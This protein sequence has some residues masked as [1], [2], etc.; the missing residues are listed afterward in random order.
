MPAEGRFQGLGGERQG[1]MCRT[2]LRRVCSRPNARRSLLS[3]IWWPARFQRVQNSSHLCKPCMFSLIW[4][5]CKFW[6]LSGLGFTAAAAH[7]PLSWSL[8]PNVWQHKPLVGACQT[9]QEMSHHFAKVRKEITK[10]EPMAIYK[11]PVGP[12]AF[13]CSVLSNSSSG[14]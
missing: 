13:R 6:R 8:G 11:E 1:A 7:H 3:H 9:C 12:N 5:V 14:H 4:K 2:Y 10:G